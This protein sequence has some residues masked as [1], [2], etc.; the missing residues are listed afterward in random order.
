[1]GD[2]ESSELDSLKVGKAVKRMR[3]SESVMAKSVMVRVHFPGS[4]VDG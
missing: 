3:K 4:R 1:M 2:S